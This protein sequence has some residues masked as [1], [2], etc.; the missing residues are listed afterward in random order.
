MDSNNNNTKTPTSNSNAFI[1][2][3][4]LKNEPFRK[5]NGRNNKTVNIIIAIPVPI[6]IPGNEAKLYR[7]KTDTN[8][9]ELNFSLLS[10]LFVIREP[11]IT[12]YYLL[13][14]RAR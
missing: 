7:K 4:S 8:A 3:L 2:P 6:N 9:K 10:I 14:E 12:F 5:T 11:F 1:V 13:K